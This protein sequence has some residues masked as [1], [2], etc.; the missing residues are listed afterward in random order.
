MLLGSVHY[1]CPGGGGKSENA[2]SETFLA[3]PPHETCETLLLNTEKK[4]FSDIYA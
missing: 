3:P 1:L 4:D 2:T